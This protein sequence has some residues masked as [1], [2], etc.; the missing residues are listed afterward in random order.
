[1]Q[2]TWRTQVVA[3]IPALIPAMPRWQNPLKGQ[4]G[5]VG[6]PVLFLGNAAGPSPA[7]FTSKPRGGES[8]QKQ[9][10]LYSPPAPCL[11][12]PKR[13]G[14]SLPTLLFTAPLR[15]SRKCLCLRSIP[16]SARP[17]S[18]ASRILRFPEPEEG[19]LETGAVRVPGFTGQRASGQRPLKAGARGRPT[20]Q[21]GRKAKR[22][23]RNLRA[24]ASAGAWTRPAPSVSY[25][26]LG[27]SKRPETP[28]GR[29]PRRIGGKTPERT[30]FFAALFTPSLPG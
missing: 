24:F 6:H 13:S 9:S 23:D 25:E 10:E 16:F 29:P 7:R 17:G 2:R 19:R 22:P 3:Y 15:E 21:R 20:P 1:M 28:L 5:W 26:V 8:Q 14:A 30:A 12:R 4:P 11:L 27:P 18:C